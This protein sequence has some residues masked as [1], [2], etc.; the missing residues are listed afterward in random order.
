VKHSGCMI[1]PDPERLE[2]LAAVL[3]ELQT[4][5][6]STSELEYQVAQLLHDSGYSWDAI[7][8]A[9][10]GISRQAARKKW[11]RPRRRRQ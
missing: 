11:A 1:P 8:E 5:V 6:T 4:I 2:R 10:G 7:G 3:N 9:A